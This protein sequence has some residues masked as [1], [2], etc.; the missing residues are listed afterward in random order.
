MNINVYCSDMN[1]EANNDDLNV[2]LQDIDVS[3]VVS[4]MPSREVLEALDFDDIRQYY[5]EQL[6]ENKE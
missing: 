1:V 6:N 5:I 4:E 2:Y 3:Q